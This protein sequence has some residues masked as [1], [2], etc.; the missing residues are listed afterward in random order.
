[1]PAYSTDWIKRL[2]KLRETDPE[3]V[4]EIEKRADQIYNDP[5][6]DVYSRG[7][8]AKTPGARYKDAG[9]D[10]RARAMEQA[11]SEYERMAGATQ[12][13]PESWMADLPEE[14]PLAGLPET[15]P[16][17]EPELEPSLETEIV[18]ADELA[19]IEARAKRSPAPKRPTMPIAED[20]TEDQPDDVDL[21]PFAMDDIK[22]LENPTLLQRLGRF[23][24]SDR[25]L[26]VLQALAKGGQAYMGGRA[27]SEANQRTRQSQA[28][29]NLIN[30]LSSRAGARGTVEKPRM[31]KLGTLFGT[32][33]DIG[34]G[35]RE[36]RT[37]ERE[38]DL[39]E[40]KLA[41]DINL[42]E[43]K[44]AADEA[45]RQATADYRSKVLEGQQAEALAAADYRKQKLTIDEAA[46]EYNRQA[47][48]FQRKRLE[49]DRTYRRGKDEQA[50]MQRQ[51]TNLSKYADSA[52]YAG[53]FDTFDE[54]VQANP[55]V[56]SVYENLDSD[57][58]M[59][60]Q[61]QFANAQNRA[62]KDGL[63]NAR[64]TAA[65]EAK[66]VAE[67]AEEW[68]YNGEAASLDEAF[69]AN[70]ELKE[71]YDSL[72]T[73]GRALI[74]A[75]FKGGEAKREK[76][77]GTSAKK[78]T[79]RELA[80]SAEIM[81]TAY[82]AIDDPSSF[83]ASKFVEGDI[84]DKPSWVTKRLYEEESTYRSL[85][86]AL[87]LQLASAFNRGRPSD[88]DYVV[89]RELL[90]I[91]G[92]TRGIAA[93]KWEALRYLISMKQQAETA[94]W[95]AEDNQEFLARIV[96]FDRGRPSVDFGEAQQFF[97]GFVP[98]TD[99]T[100]TADPGQQRRRLREDVSLKDNQ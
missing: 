18:S 12:P 83:L 74:M 59:F 32:L 20:V 41:S 31:G 75:K 19:E 91:I 54:F 96:N 9:R 45:A 58:Q 72:N 15:E 46:A 51:A 62:K 78:L 8:V 42:R 7:G 79:F 25:G 43:R 22:E 2:N 14:D 52:A 27:Q 34:G 76:E 39:K 56:R 26:A 88:K 70:P 61:G 81:K 50:E 6:Y 5:G 85:R 60:V 99:Q 38:R 98:V 80:T 92:D 13:E 94:G 95:R 4:R 49:E 35:L 33:A 47:K 86:D 40:R 53:A 84:E 28:R 24:E 37:L 67:L 90:P 3:A 10:S 100:G 30:A 82:D 1:M 66:N 63:A 29:A 89:A 64:I 44:L 71:L 77:L 68:G 55:S 16:E 57:N 36:E 87:S 17:T 48:E 11:L 21:L 73:S 23:A 65:Q 93:A 69:A 97:Q